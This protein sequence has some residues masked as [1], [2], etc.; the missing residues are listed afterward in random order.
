MTPHNDGFKSYLVN[1]ETIGGIATH[2]AG[3]LSSDTQHHITQINQFGCE[4]RAAT[5]L[6]SVIKEK[7]DMFIRK[8]CAG[9]RQTSPMPSGYYSYVLLFVHYCDLHVT[10]PIIIMDPIDH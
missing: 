9:S 7:C 10:P 5:S 2:H 4:G 3:V 6:W 8:V 1:R